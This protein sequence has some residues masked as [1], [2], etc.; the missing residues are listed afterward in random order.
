[1]SYLTLTFNLGYICQHVGTVL[2]LIKVEKKKST[3]AVCLDTQILFFIGAIS[4]I[5]WVKDTILNESNLTYVEVITAILSLAYT[6]YVYMFKYNYLTII[7]SLNKCSIPVI[8]RWY[9]ILVV[10]TI[11]SLIFFPGN[12]EGNY[13][14]D[15]QTLVSFNIFVESSGLLPQ[16]FAIHKERDSNNFSRSYIL[17]LTILLCKNGFYVFF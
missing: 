14:Y 1:M 4:R 10:S 15:S 12:E 11:L 5:I 9:I 6:L 17:F 7:Q 2:Q 16:I 3:E 8:F 13:Q